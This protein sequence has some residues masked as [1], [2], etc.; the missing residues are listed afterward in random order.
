MARSL[1]SIQDLIFDEWYANIPGIEKF[2]EWCL[3][4]NFC[5]ITLAVEL[6]NASHAEKLDVKLFSPF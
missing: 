3:H 5:S 6:Y 2:R 1:S 4:Q